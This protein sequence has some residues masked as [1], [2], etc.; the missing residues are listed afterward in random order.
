MKNINKIIGKEWIEAHGYD[1]YDYGARNYYPAIMR[2]TT[3]DPMAEKYYSVSPYAYCANNPVNAIDLH[4]DTITTVIV[5]AFTD[6]NGTQSI[7]ETKYYYGKDKNGK[8]GFLDSSGNLYSGND[9]F[10]NSLTTALNKL[11]T[12]GKAGSSLVS[13]LVSST[14][15][16][17][18]AFGKKNA[19]GENGT[20]IH[21]N[22]TLN[23]G[24][25]NKFGKVDRPTY[26]G[27]GHEMAH[28]Q[29][30]WKGTYDKNIWITVAGTPIPNAEKYSTHIE[31]QLRAENNILLR[32]HY[33]RG[34]EKSRIINKVGESLFYKNSKGTP[35]SYKKK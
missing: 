21:W 24:G 29:D 13:D 32:T 10:V 5:N 22:N 4:G 7:K 3:I 31:N 35:F 34:E 8:Y 9:K 14:K 12:G 23:R 25:V 18:I 17:Q 28:I 30:V 20:F 6:K 26:I 1:N 11:R 2:F 15:N 19:A 16:V 33:F 27:L